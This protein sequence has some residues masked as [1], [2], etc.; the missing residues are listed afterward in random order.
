MKSLFLNLCRSLQ[1]HTTGF[2][3]IC[4]LIFIS[5]CKLPIADIYDRLSYSRSSTIWMKKYMFIRILYNSSWFIVLTPLCKALW[6]KNSEKRNLDICKILIIYRLA[7]SSYHL[8]ND[9]FVMGYKAAKGQR[10]LSKAKKPVPDRI[11]AR[12]LLPGPFR[13]SYLLTELKTPS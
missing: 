12:S 11:R 3:N 2:Y 10:P 1:G 6:W 13:K 4:L 7:P 9:P 8:L 5:K